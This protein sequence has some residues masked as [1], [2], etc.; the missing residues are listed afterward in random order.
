VLAGNCNAC[1][2]HN[3]RPDVTAYNGPG[4][5]SNHHGLKKLAAAAQLPYH[6]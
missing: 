4:C 2:G 1:I 6:S 5:D 3:H